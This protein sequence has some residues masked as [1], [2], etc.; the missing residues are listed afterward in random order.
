MLDEEGL[1]PRVITESIKYEFMTQVILS[2]KME[3]GKN[4][5]LRPHIASPDMQ[6]YSYNV[7]NHDF[8]LFAI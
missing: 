2:M 8:T 6:G 4:L 5:N 1:S 3:V 7:V